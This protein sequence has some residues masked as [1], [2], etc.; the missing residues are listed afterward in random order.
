MLDKQDI[1]LLKKWILEMLNIKYNRDYMH[2]YIADNYS[3]EIVKEKLLD[4]Y[5]SC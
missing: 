5:F 3:W 2:K 1:E 4:L